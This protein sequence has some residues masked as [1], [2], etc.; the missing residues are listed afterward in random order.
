MDKND[1]IV[2]QAK[3]IEEERCVRRGQ[4][5]ELDKLKF[6]VKCV[7]DELHKVGLKAERKSQEAASECKEKTSLLSALKEKDLSLDH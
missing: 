7:N 3:E 5:A 6:K 4:Q 2:K 1:L